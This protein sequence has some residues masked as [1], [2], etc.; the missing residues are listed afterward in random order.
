M[1]SLRGLVAAALAIAGWTDSAA[2]AGAVRTTDA[3][4]GAGGGVARTTGA[5]VVAV[6]LR[7]PDN[8]G[9]VVQAATA[10]NSAASPA[11]AACA[12]GIARNGSTE[13][14][15]EGCAMTRGEPLPAV[16]GTLYV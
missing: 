13:G 7:A 12:T 3:G 1:P 11:R 15:D 16:A 5:A 10:M 14:I 8:G 2:G 9:A 6:A 4:S